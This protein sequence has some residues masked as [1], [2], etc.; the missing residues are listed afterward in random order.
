ML[1]FSTKPGCWERHVQRQYAY[2]HLFA[3][4]ATV[5]QQEIDIAERTD[6]AERE[7]FHK[8]F[9]VLLQE[10][11]RFQRTEKTEIVLDLKQRIDSMYERTAGLGGDFSKE[12]EGLRNLVELIM[13]AI[14]DTGT[15]DDHAVRELEK[16]TQAR[17]LHFHL[18]EH[19]VIAHLLRPDS[20]IGRDEI[21]PS[22]LCEDEASLQAAM[23][24]FTEEQRG[25]LA[26][27]GRE[28]LLRLRAEGADTLELWRR[29]AVLERPP[30]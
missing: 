24:L 3:R 20:P 7:A 19:S 18:L 22:L 10:I 9:V 12:Q 8:D 1:R 29:L 15:H 6:Q 21:V 28:I 16:E 2:P 14:R 26:Q 4:T 25:V 30:M 23:M 27:V 11:S 5:T 17:A 13:Q